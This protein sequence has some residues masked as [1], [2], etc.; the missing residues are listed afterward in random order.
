MGIEE[1]LTWPFF[2]ENHRAFAAALA[3]WADASIPH[4]S[5]DGLQLGE[6]SWATAG[7]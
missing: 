2:D 3:R 6:G 4:N 1:T 7:R 5:D